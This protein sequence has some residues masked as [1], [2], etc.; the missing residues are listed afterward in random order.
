MKERTIRAYYVFS[1]PTR[2]FHWV[3]VVCVTVLLG[4]GLYIGNPFFLGTQG[5]EA[6]FAVTNVFSMEKMRFYHFVAAYLL[7]S[8]FILRCYGWII[9]KGDRL[10]PRFWTRHFWEGLVDTTLHYTFLRFQHRPYLRN[11][12][13]RSS[14]L[15]IYLLLL[16]EAVTGM[17]MYVMIT[18]NSWP[19]S[20]FGPINHLLGDEYTVH[21]VHHYIAWILVIFVIVHVYMATRADWMEKGGEVSGMISGVKFYDEEPEDL[22]DIR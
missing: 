22:S 20:L 5:Q 17:A 6:T 13:A 12:L 16:T 19:A 10:L 9:N 4:T 15:A 18:P 2:I 8:F 11:S 14:Y 3:M 21:I 7:L 1:A